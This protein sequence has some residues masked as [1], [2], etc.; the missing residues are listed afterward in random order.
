MKN[1]F[2]ELIDCI[3]TTT[4]HNHNRAESKNEQGAQSI[5]PIKALIAVCI[6]PS[7]NLMS[8]DYT[9]SHF[10]GYVSKT[11]PNLYYGFRG[12]F[13]GWLLS[14]FPGVHFTRHL[15]GILRRNPAMAQ[16]QQ[17]RI[18]SLNFG[19]SSLFFF[20]APIAQNKHSFIPIKRGISVAIQTISATKKHPMMWL[21]GVTVYLW[22]VPPLSTWPFIDEFHFI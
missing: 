2:V 17:L 4:G 18:Y 13:G 21:I 6:F 9:Y 1:I 15:C 3:F 10:P 22:H 11:R 19:A 16:R 12:S 5:C 14:G 7:V 20:F 8:S